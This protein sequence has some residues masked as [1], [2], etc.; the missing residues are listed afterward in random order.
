MLLYR[1]VEK[2]KIAH[3]ISLKMAVTILSLLLLIQLLAIPASG[4]VLQ[5]KVCKDQFAHASSNGQD[6]FYINGNSVE[7]AL[8]CDALQT[9]YAN[10]CILEGYLGS[11][12]CGSVLSLGM[13]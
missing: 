6:L 10:G 2:M 8:F 1:F 13:L 9:Y 7:K 11:R 12:Y 4:L 5:S 3:I